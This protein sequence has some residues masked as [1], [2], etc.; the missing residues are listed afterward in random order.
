MCK[1]T[2]VL[3]HNTPE[4]EAGAVLEYNDSRGRYDVVNFSEV[5]RYELKSGSYF[6]FHKDVVEK[7]GYWFELVNDCD[8]DCHY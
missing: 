6:S 7:E 5:A 2:Y 1:R 8:C 4:V 3:K